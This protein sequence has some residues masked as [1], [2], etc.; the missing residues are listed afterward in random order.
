MVQ[1]IIVFS[2]IIL[3]VLIGFVGKNRSKTTKGYEGTGLGLLLCVVAGVVRRYSH[4][5]NS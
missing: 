1:I 3:T 5:R 4:N 2:Y